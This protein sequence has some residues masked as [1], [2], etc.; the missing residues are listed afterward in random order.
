[1]KLTKLAAAVATTA[2]LSLGAVQAQ[3]ADVTLRFGHIWPAVA[4]THQNIFQP[5]ADQVHQT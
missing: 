2:T 5:W 4:G 3:A 1:M